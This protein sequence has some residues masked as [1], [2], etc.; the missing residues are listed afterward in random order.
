MTKLSLILRIVLI[1]LMAITG[2]FI[3]LFYFGGA[4]E[5]TE[6]TEFYEPSVTEGMLKWTYALFFIALAGAIGFPASYIL[7]NPETA[8]KTL[9]SVLFIGV[10]V[11]IAYLLADDTV[12]NMPGYKGEDNVP[13]KLQWAGTGLITTYLLFGIALL[14]IIGSEVLKIVRK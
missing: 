4:V 7:K 3:I 5:G 1:V 12:L 13:D 11:L 8:K 6:G 9:I 10:V 14:S 2:I